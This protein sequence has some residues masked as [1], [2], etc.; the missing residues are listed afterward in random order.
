MEAVKDALSQLPGL[1]V[2]KISDEGAKAL[3]VA[4]E[5]PR[6]SVKKLEFSSTSIVATSPSQ[7]KVHQ[8]RSR[9]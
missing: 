1:T 2:G 4:L 9:P 6:S 3:A 7:R 8:T 5:S